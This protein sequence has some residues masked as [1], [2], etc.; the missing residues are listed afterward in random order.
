MADFDNK[1]T[2]FLAVKQHLLLIKKLDP[3]IF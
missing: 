2:V 1:I 3:H